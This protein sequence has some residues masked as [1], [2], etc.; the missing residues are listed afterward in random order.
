MTTYDAK[1]AA[2]FKA[3]LDTYG[4]WEWSPNKVDAILVNA[5]DNDTVKLEQLIDFFA[6]V[7]VEYLG[8]GNLQTIFDAGFKTIVDVINMSEFEWTQMIGA[9][10][11]KIHKSIREKL[12]NVPWYVVAGAH[13]AFGRGVGVRKMKKLYEAFAG[14]MRKLGDINAIQAVEGFEFKTAS[15]IS[16]GFVRGFIK[17]LTDTSA[18]I[19][20]AP[21][22]APKTGT[23]SG[24]TFL[25]TG[26]R[27]S[28]LEAKIVE[29]G[30][31]ISSSVS[32]KLTYLVAADVNDSS[33]KLKKAR[34][35]GTK[36]ISREE[37]I[38][39]LGE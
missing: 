24:Q 29:Q 32:S 15:K 18:T 17:F 38:E 3:Q 37:L 14:D 7:G 39:L 5:N 10:G 19:T 8:E 1:Y 28:D 6:K 27:S 23:L 26:F 4:E 31:K 11:R 9:N 34:D 35:I 13:P 16:S 2:W 36:I 22:E 20:F 21:Y 33:G 12:T 25:F 30:G